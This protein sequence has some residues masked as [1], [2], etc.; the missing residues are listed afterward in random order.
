[1][2]RQRTI[3]MKIKENPEASKSFVRGGEI[4]PVDKLE[5]SGGTGLRIGFI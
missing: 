4:R 1:M 2:E 3:L 5:L